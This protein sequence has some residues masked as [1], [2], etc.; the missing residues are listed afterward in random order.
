MKAIVITAPS[1]AGK[2]TLV[3]LLLEERK[4][5]EFSVSACTREKR[6]FET[7][8]KDYYFLKIGDFKNKIANND[9][10]EWEEVYTDMYYGTLKKEVERIWAKNKNVIFD[11]DVKGAVNVKKQLKDKVLTIFIK[12][13]NKDEL[14]KRLKARGTETEKTIKK[15]FDRSVLELAFEKQF[16]KVIVNDKLD[17]AFE[18]LKIVVDEFL[19]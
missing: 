6:E 17:V 14:Y 19:F 7:H 9:F 2:T 1:G 12:P 4:D 15:R 10:I 3:K 18:E 16:D 11:I 5:L 13:P 8:K